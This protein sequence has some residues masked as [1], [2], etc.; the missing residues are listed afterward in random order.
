[1][2]PSELLVLKRYS[3]DNPEPGILE[4]NGIFWHKTKV[5]IFLK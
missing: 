2:A 5:N 1:M 4:E 3:S